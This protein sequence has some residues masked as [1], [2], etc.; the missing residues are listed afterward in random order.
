MRTEEHYERHGGYSPG[1]DEETIT[2]WCSCC[3]QACEGIEVDNGIGPYEF[4]GQ[5][6]THKQIDIESTCCNAPLLDDNPHPDDEDCD[7]DIH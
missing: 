1:D 6:G 5:K 4:W 2:G 3:E 7:V